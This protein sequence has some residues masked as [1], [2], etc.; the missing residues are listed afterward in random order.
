VEGECKHERINT[1]IS[2]KTLLIVDIEGFEVSFLDPVKLPN[3]LETDLLVEIH[4]STEFTKQATAEEQLTKRFAASHIIERR[5]VSDRENWIE[6]HHDL[7]RDKV[8]YEQMTKA[9]DEHRDSSGLWL[10]AKKA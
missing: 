9:L 2:N 4:E 1:L 6:E 3:L 5:V 7:W 8:S 10:W